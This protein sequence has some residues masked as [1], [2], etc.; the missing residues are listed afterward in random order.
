MKYIFTFSL[1]FI[2]GLTAFAQ[3]DPTYSF[4]RYN[5]NFVNPAY[6]GSNT[7]EFGLNVRSQWASV[8]GAPETQS[9]F[10]AAPM[11][12]NVSLG[13]SIVNDR[14]FIENQTWLALDF[15]Y[16]LTL[17]ENTNVYF[18]L[19]TGLNSYKANTDG[20][21]S[22]DIQPDPSLENLSS[23][24]NPNIGIG[25]YIKHSDY[26]ISVSVPKILTS[27][28]LENSDGEAILN[29]EKLH[30]YTSAGYDFVLD[31]SWTFKP[32]IMARIVEGLPLSVELTGAFA[33]QDR[34]EFGPSYR[35]EE[36]IGAFFIFKATKALHLGYAY[37]SALDKTIARANNGSHE[38]L[39]KLYL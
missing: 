38:I 24:F 27:N 11:G 13:I 30:L 9:V 31:G 6:A 34:F 14:T 17:N 35:F 5:M 22:Y 32:S 25:V 37:E 4:Y 2:C 8:E 12:R 1:I 26:Y 15:S 21:V 19:K 39:L 29:E 16:Q 3:Q 28:R 20:L 33:L 23:R 7:T 10:F 36:G 18:G